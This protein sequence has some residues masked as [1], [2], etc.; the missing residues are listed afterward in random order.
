[1]CPIQGQEDIHAS[2]HSRGKD[3]GILRVDDL[4]HVSDLLRCRG[5]SE[6]KVETGDLLVEPE[7]GVPSELRLD[8]PLGLQED[9][10][11][12]HGL[13]MAMPAHVQHQG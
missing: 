9:K 12:A 2:L 3:M 6:I 13:G 1:M 5:F 8:V 10:M 4:T 11:A 7:Q